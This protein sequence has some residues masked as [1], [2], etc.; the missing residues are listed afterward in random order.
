MADRAGGGLMLLLAAAAA[1]A[2]T[3]LGWGCAR[4]LLRWTGYAVAAGFLIYHVLPV[5][6]P[7]AFPYWGRSDVGL[8]QWL[9]VLA[10]VAIGVWCGLVAGQRQRAVK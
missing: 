2:G 1:T 7:L 6:G 3:A 9:P 8:V 10:A 5:P 4:P